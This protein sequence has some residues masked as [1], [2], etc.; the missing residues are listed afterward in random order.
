MN[1]FLSLSSHIT[2]IRYPAGFQ[3]FIDETCQTFVDRQFVFDALNDFLQRCDRGYF[4][5]TGSPG[6]GKTTILA[7]YLI[8]HP[9]TFYYITQSLNTQHPDHF[10]K[11]ICTQLLNYLKT[12]TTDD[13][14]E[15]L[16]N[17]VT[18]GSSSLCLLLQKISNELPSSQSL[19]IAIDAIE[20]RNFSHYSPGCNLFYLPRYLPPRIYFLLSRRPFPP[21][22]SCLFIE[23]PSQS[24]NLDHYPNQTRVDIQTYIQKFLTSTKQGAVIRAYITTH[25]ISEAEFCQTLIT[26]SENNFMYLSKLIPTIARSMDSYLTQVKCLPLELEQYYYHYWQGMKSKRLSLVAGT[27]LHILIKQNQPMSIEMIAVA[28]DEDEYEVAKILASWS[29]FLIT[30][31]TQGVTYYNFYHSSFRNF[32]AQQL[33][34]H[35]S[36]KENI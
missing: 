9:L 13:S 31:V 11:T 21:E 5:L 14:C 10:L 3:Q 4:T 1:N 17:N 8:N 32:I 7:K 18:R 16:L 12:I 25:D 2:N 36:W 29:E 15:T 34:K 24:L 20:R 23:A 28:I 26:A 35:Y 19:V 22:K 6:S 27:I 30:Q 33:S